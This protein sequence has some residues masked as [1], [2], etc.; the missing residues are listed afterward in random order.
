MQSAAAAA[1]FTPTASAPW[2]DHGYPTPGEQGCLVEKPSLCFLT[3]LHYFKD[4]EVDATCRQP[5]LHAQPGLDFP[6]PPP[7]EM[8]YLGTFP[9]ASQQTVSCCPI[10]W[11][12]HKRAIC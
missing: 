11:E 3:A 6:P 7:Q 1:P 12:P 4:K 10:K 2:T 8:H 5:L 9:T